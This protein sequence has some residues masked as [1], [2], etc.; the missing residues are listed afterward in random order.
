MDI[1]DANTGDA[2]AI[3]RIYNGYV[4]DTTT[5]FELDEVDDA[6]M[7][8]RIGEV[9]SRGLP[10]LVAEAGGQVQGYAYAG[11]WKSR[12]AYARTVEASIYLSPSVVGKGWGKRLYADLIERLRTAGIHVVIG[13]VSLQ[14]AAS[15]R[16]HEGLGFEYVGR[17]REV[18]RKFDRWVDVGYWQRI[19]R[20]DE[21]PLSR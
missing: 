8:R 12:T 11:P 21:Q 1:R 14:N 5:T 18:G 19:L 10:W 3:A 6:E 13:G 9:Q 17:F 16:L 15:V 4:R 7:T 2:A 20:D